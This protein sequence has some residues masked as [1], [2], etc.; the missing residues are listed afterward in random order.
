VVTVVGLLGSYA[1]YGLA[2]D[3]L[4]HLTAGSLSRRTLPVPAQGM[5]RRAALVAG[6]GVIAA[7]VTGELSGGFTRAPHAAMTACDIK[8]Q[9]FS[10]LRQ[11]T[12]FM[13]L[14]GTSSTR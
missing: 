13:W 5:G 4:Y 14:A 3:G 9:T 8:A 11:L 12:A 10:R 7:A 1:A 6:V 2:L